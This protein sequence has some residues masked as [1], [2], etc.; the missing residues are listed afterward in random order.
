MVGVVVAVG[1]GG[2]SVGGTSVKVGVGVIGVGVGIGVFVGGKGVNVLVA[3]GFNKA[4]SVIS[5]MAVFM[6]SITIT[7]YVAVN[8]AGASPDC[9]NELNEHPLKIIKD[10]EKKKNR[11]NFRFII[12]FLNYQPL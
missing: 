10:T 5:P 12:T 1:G 3:L 7:S 6:A 8:S 4:C 2:V 11:R 9:P